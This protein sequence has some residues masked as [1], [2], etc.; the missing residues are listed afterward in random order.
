[1]LDS[2]MADDMRDLLIPDDP[3]LRGPATIVLKPL[4]PARK[5]TV[6]V[7][8]AWI[9]PIS[10][11]MV[12]YSQFNISG[13]ETLIHIPDSQLNPGNEGREIRSDDQIVFNGIRYNVTA[14]GTTLKTLQTDWVCVCKKITQN[15]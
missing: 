2:A 12:Q 7:T 8:D 10:G 11:K 9:K 13:D 1:M 15:G 4:A 14:A 5:E 3:K 6:T